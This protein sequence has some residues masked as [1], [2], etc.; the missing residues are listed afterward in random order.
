MDLMLKEPVVVDLMLYMMVVAVVLLWDHGG[1]STLVVF[2]YWL[3]LEA[4]V[5]TLK[6]LYLQNGYLRSASYFAGF[7]SLKSLR[8]L[9]NTRV[10]EVL[11]I[12]TMAIGGD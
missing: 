2:F 5:S 10:L 1:V 11:C 3:L 8:L 4:N 7:H 12:K 6:H 9:S